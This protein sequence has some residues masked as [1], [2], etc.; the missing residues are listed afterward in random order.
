MHMHR[1]TVCIELPTHLLGIRL[2]RR[3]AFT[4]ERSPCSYQ[5]SIAGKLLS[6][7]SSGV[8]G[9]G[10]IQDALSSPTPVT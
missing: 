7:H 10:Q 5:Y 1:R 6:S 8:G 3:I 9:V 4:A 2:K